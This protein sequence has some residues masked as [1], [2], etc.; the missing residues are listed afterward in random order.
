[1]SGGVPSKGLNEQLHDILD[2]LAINSNLLDD[3]N[4]I[5]NIMFLLQAG[6]DPN[7]QNQN[8]KT[9]LDYLNEELLNILNQLAIDSNLLD[10]S[11]NTQYIMS[12]LQAGANPNVQNQ[13]GKALLHY[14]AERNDIDGIRYFLGVI[15]ANPSIR[16]QS[17]KTPF[18]YV[19]EPDC[20][21][22]LKDLGYISNNKTT[23]TK[24]SDS[25]KNS[26]YY[27]DDSRENEESPANN[28]S[29][30][31]N[32]HNDDQTLRDDPGYGSGDDNKTISTEPSDCDRKDEDSSCSSS[33]YLF[34]ED[35][36]LAKLEI[37][38]TTDE[39]KLIDK[40]CGE[41]R[42]ITAQ[43]KQESEE[44]ILESIEK[45]VN[46]YLKKGLRLNSSCSNDNE[47]GDKETVT[48]LILEEIEG[49]LSDRVK[50]R[51]GTKEYIG[52]V[53]DITDQDDDNEDKVSGIIENITNRL[54]LKGGKAR[55]KFFFGNTELAQNYRSDYIS[56]LGEKYKEIKDKLIS[57]AYESIVNKSKQTHEYDFKAEIDNG[58]FCI[59]YPRD[60]IIDPAKIFNKA[61]ALDL[62]VGIIKIGESIVR[63]EGTKDGK[64]N[65]T[66]ILKGR[67]KMSFTTEVGKISIYLSPSKKD[68]NKIEVEIDEE[69]KARLNKLK[70]EKKS[71]GENYLLG[72][73]SVLEAIEAKGFKKNGNVPTEPTE[74]I[75]DVPFTD[76]T[77][78][79]LQQIN[80]RAKG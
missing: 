40:F 28:S 11:N 79:Y 61:E 25:E 49:V 32:K 46:E 39:Q 43:N 12:L 52:R 54:L 9:P 17:G 18:E 1:M 21:Q 57:I 44:S 31:P 36:L 34:L 68:G 24:L 53:N 76:F 67:I 73:E 27:S 3:S 45:I 8:G 6:A 62:K 41:I 80:T 69:N 71:L 64:K 65:C 13:A 51:D 14:V 22:A 42:G 50:P 15:K 4:C 19:T 56:N 26:D 70:A 10:N 58:Y 75:K 16:D 77:Q 55:Q 72:G 23:C 33:D 7:I 2:Q 78:A 60:S 59:E 47:K 66:D 74:T 38:L 5:Q 48:N 29:N 63:V 35:S 20:L 37:P 30:Y